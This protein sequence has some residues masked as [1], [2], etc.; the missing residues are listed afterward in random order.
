MLI[1]THALV[2]GFFASKISN[3]IISSPLIFV[4]HFLLDHIPH[5]DLGTGFR[6]RKK[7]V[8]FLLGLADLI[9]TIGICW[10]IF[11]K[12]L[13][14]N[15]LVWIGILFSILPDFLEFPPLFLG[16][17]FFPFGKLET[18]HSQII[19]RRAKFPQGLIPQILIIAGILLLV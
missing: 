8:N 9:G 15:L 17:R 6:K 1:I 14:F 13:P 5:W 3:P 4:S 18:F 2:G 12:N 16:W 11:Q 10:F 7:I 19:H